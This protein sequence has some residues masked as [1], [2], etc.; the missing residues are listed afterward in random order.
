MIEQAKSACVSDRAAPVFGRENFIFT[1]SF[2]F[3]KFLDSAAIT[4]A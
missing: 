4:L 2:K 3:G 1:I